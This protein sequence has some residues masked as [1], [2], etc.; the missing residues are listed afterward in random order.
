[1]VKEKVAGLSFHCYAFHITNYTV[2]P[3]FSDC[4]RNEYMNKNIYPGREPKYSSHSVSML[5]A[6]TLLQ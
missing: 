1:M 2:R 5:S 3:L 4:P 6:M